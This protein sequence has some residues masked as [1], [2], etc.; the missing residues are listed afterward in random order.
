MTFIVLF[1]ECVIKRQE[2]MQQEDEWTKKLDSVCDKLNLVCVLES[3]FVNEKF[4]ECCSSSAQKAKQTQGL[5]VFKLL[6]R[7]ISLD[8][9]LRAL[10]SLSPW[11]TAKYRYPR[12]D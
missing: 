12:R 8:I 1:K 7:R 11:E 10:P 9:K 6:S 2:S 3:S 5:F 4:I